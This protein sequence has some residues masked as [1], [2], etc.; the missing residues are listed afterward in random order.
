MAAFE[1]YRDGKH[2]YRWRLRAGNRRIIAD[3][4]EGYHNR[5]HCE[6]GI[7]LLRTATAPEFYRDT[8]GGHRWR[9][10]AD[11]GRTIADSGE[12][13]ATAA[14][15]RRGFAAVQRSAAQAP[16]KII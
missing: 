13:Y 4:G 11:N 3:S 12:A 2:E 14:G 15:C 16:L 5:A 8:G 7:D 6:H 1:L 10:Q 9:L